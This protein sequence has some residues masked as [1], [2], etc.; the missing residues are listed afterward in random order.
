MLPARVVA[1]YDALEKITERVRGECRF[2]LVDESNR[3]ALDGQFEECAARY[4]KATLIIGDSHA[5]NVYDALAHN[6]DAPFMIRAAQGGCQASRTVSSCQYD[7]VAVFVADH[8]DRIGRVVYTQAGVWLV[9]GAGGKVGNRGIFRRPDIKVYQENTPS[10]ERVEAY[11]TTL[12]KQVPVIWLGAYVE[13]HLTIPPLFRHARNCELGIS[14]V[15]PNTI[16][17]FENL[18][19]VLKT[20]LSSKAVKYI[21]AVDALQFDP[22][23]DLYDCENVFWRDGDHWTKAGQRR[24]GERLLAAHP[25]LVGEEVDSR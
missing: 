8:A 14:E 2:S 9:Q 19:R 6:S 10:L 13:P 24:F 12:S 25:E 21:S 11:L 4:G 3:S 17:T 22:Y 20:R 7:F 16:R 23:V 5:N 18:D 1:T 15:H